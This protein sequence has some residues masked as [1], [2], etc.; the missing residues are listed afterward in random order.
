[1]KCDLAELRI[2]KNSETA[3]ETTARLSGTWGDRQASRRNERKKMTWQ[4]RIRTE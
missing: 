4:Q 1:M 3:T 2:D